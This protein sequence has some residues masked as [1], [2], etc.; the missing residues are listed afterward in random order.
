[1]HIAI[2]LIIALFTAMPA[3]ADSLVADTLKRAPVL[4]PN[5]SPFP[6]SSL[7]DYSSRLEAPA[8]KRGFV[9][10]K[11]G[12]FVYAD[13][14]RARFFG[15]NLA[16]DTVFIEKPQIER[17]AALFARAGVNL[18]RIHHIDDVQG[19]L[20][21][22][23]NHFFR[24]ER[25]DLVDYW[26]AKLKERGIYVCLDLND[27]RTFRSSEGVVEGEQLGRGAKPYAVFDPTLV[28]LQQEY[29]ERFLVEHVNPYT[30]LP[31]ANDPAIA[32]LEIYDENGLFIRR[33]DWSKLQEPYKSTLRREWNAWLRYRYNNTAALKA[34]WTDRT[35]ACA[36]T[37]AESLEQATVQLPNLAVGSD[38]PTSFT[39][40]LLAPA[41]VSDGAIFAYD[42]QVNYLQT[43]MNYLRKIGVRVPVT[44]VGAQDIIPDLLATANATDY[45]GINYY[46]DHPVFDPGK[47]WTLPYYF[48]LKNPVS[49]SLDFSF[50]AVVS[51]AR[52]HKKPLV[53]RELGYCFPNLYRGVGTL[54][55]AAYGA[56]LDIDAIILFTYDAHS[57]AR[58]IGY[59]DIHLDPLR[60]GL[61]AQAGR[62]FLGGEVQPAKHTVGIGYSEVD[63][64]SWFNYASP[65]HQ[66]AFHTRVVNYTD[67]GTPHPLDLLVASGRS[68]GSMWMGERLLLFANQ[69]HT[70]LKFQGTADGLDERHGYSIATGRSGLFN[71]TFQGIG[72]DAGATQP[73]QAWPV[74]NVEDINAKGFKPVGIAEGTAA[75]G[76][77]DPAH[78]VFLFHNLKYD[79]ASRVAL[80]AL[81]DWSGAAVSH[82]SI[83]KGIYNSDTRQLQR[84]LH[85]RVLTIDTPTMQAIVGRFDTGVQRTSALALTSPTPIGTISAESLDGKPLAESER[86][87]LKMTS[88]ARNDMMQLTPEPKGPKPFK[89]YS[90]GSPPIR[91][92]GVASK[93]PTRVE[94]GGKPLFE[95]YLQNGTWEY[96]AEPGHALLYL[97]TGDVRVTL[98][99]QAKLIRWHMPGNV[100][101]LEPTSPMFT[102][103]SGVLYTEIIW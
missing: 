99:A 17:L 71:F 85:T 42:M 61:V 60:W 66:L 25:L 52:M 57:K 8:G 23:P 67:M 22:D 33:A 76:F 27:Y 15:I 49:D 72:Y 45:I 44:A 68:C 59:F 101:E 94:L 90:L 1:M 95:L 20:D 84:N 19:I 34:A 74:Y 69:R 86:Y 103:P 97:D 50:P 70:D 47:D 80:D 88:K 36:L 83:D 93:A 87:L 98:P 26:V 75:L 6:E 54:E 3:L 102:V 43:M 89:L 55:S 40:A 79:H 21:P 16:K 14:T 39:N 64:F 65:L 77:Q 30:K 82:Q 12:H 51:L 2:L 32:F 63:A 7:L 92:D 62:L 56:F 38:L 91:T 35:G 48:S 41:R 46:W 4:N 53:V 13:G 29:A 28:K 18:V 81:R 58:T 37:G 73:A 11:D 10:V 24:K 100:I 5:F 96:L 9:T 31:Y 78:K